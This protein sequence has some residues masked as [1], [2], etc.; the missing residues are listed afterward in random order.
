M[1]LKKLSLAISILML[2]FSPF[3]WNGAEVH[4][5][6][7]M[8][9]GTLNPDSSALLHIDN[10]LQ[11]KGL[12]IPR[13]GTADRDN[14]SNPAN[15]LLIYNTECNVFNYYK[16]DHWVSINGITIS[17]GTILGDPHP[18]QVDTA[19]YSIPQVAG[20]SN[21]IWTVP[22]GA[23]ILSGQGTNTIT[24]LFGSADGNVC[25]SA[26]NTCGDADSLCLSI[27]LAT[28]AFPPTA[29]AP[30]DFTCTSV[31]ANW[32][33]VVNTSQYLLYV[34][35]NNTFSSLLSGYPVS[36]PSNQTSQ[37][38]SGLSQ[39]T[40]YYYRVRVVN[41][42]DTS[43]YSNVVSF[44]TIPPAAPT[45]TAASN[46][47]CTGF[48]A[49][50]GPIVGV[51]HYLLEVST[52]S[53]F[54]SLLNGYPDSL[55]SSN[56]YALVGPIQPNTTYYYRVR[57]A[58]SCD[59][60]GY[61]NTVSISTSAP[62]APTA[63]AA[64]DFQCNPFS[65]RA[66]WGA[67]LAAVNY[68][69]DVSTDPQFGTYVGPYHNFTSGGNTS[70]VI[71][72]AVQG[73]ATY[74]YRIRALGCDTSGYSNTILA[75]TYPPVA[76]VATPPSNFT[77][78]SFSANWEAVN[79]AIT[80][81]LDVALDAGFTSYVTGYNDTVIGNVL[82][83]N[84][85]GLTS[86]ITYYYRVRA[87]DGCNISGNSNV[88]TLGTTAPV[89]PTATPADIYN[90]TTAN[91]NWG[92]VSG[93]TQYYIDLSIDINFSTFVNGIH[94]S[95]VGSVTT[96]N[97]GN[98]PTNT[99]YYFRVRAFNGCDTSGYSN[100]VAFG[101]TTPIAPTAT[102]ADN[103][104]CTSANAN[105][106]AV[107]G[108][109][110][111]YLD[112]SDDPGFATF[113]NN[114]HNVE[115]IGNNTTTYNITGL[116]TNTTYYY[117]VRSYN[118]CDTST[119]SNRI[120]FGT[121]PPNAPTATPADGYT[122]TSAYINWG[123]VPGAIGY[124]IDVAS[125]S[126]YLPTT[127]LPAYDSL[128]VQN[129]T[130]YNIDSLTPNTTYYFRVRAYNGC[131]VSSVSN[132]V[133]F[134]TSAPT[135]PTVTPPTT[136]N[137]TSLTASWG[138]VAGATDYI[139]EVSM[140]VN[141]VSYVNG[142][143]DS[144]GNVTSFTV[145]GLTP[146]VYYYY[147]V[148]AYNGCTVSTWSNVIS[149]GTT[150]P[151]APTATAAT[152]FSCT[153]FN[154]N[155]G[156]VQGASNYIL[157]V[158]TTPTFDNTSILPAYNNLSV[159]NVTTYHV[160]SLPIN[161]TYY[162][163]V[164]ADN[165][166]SISTFSNRIS[167]GTTAP[168]APTAT[169]ASDYT[170]TSFN[171][172]WGAVVGAT[173]YIL[174]VATTASFG[175]STLS[176]Y[177]NLNVGP[178][179]T[180]NVDSLTPNVVYFYRVRAYSGCDTSG[181]SNPVVVGTTSPTAPTA[182]PANN[183]S[184][185][186]FSANW[187]SVQGAI[188]Y[189]IDV[190]VNASF[191]SNT[192]VGN[193]LNYNA[194]PVNTLSI[195]G[196]STNV[197]YYYRVRAFNGCD[198]STYS[199]IINAGTTPPIAPTATPGSD[200]TCN[201]FNANW[202]AVSG[203]INYLLDVS[204]DP[205]FSSFVSG[206]QGQ[207]TANVTTFNVIGLTAGVNY[208]YRVRSDNGCDTSGYSNVVAVGTTAPIA[209]TATPA[210][211]FT[212]TSFNANW[213]A[214]TGATAY[215][216]DVSTDINFATGFR[217][218][219]KFVGNATTFNVDSLL[220]NTTYFYR[221]RASNGCLASGASNTITVA[222]TAPVAPTAT[223]PDNFTCTSFNANWGAVTGAI[224]YILDVA[225]NP[226]FSPNLTGYDSINV[227]N[228][229][230]YNISGL[231]SGTTYYYRVRATNGCANSNYS[232]AILVSTT[233][234]VAPTATDA[235]NF[236]C[237]SFNANW[238]AVSGATQYYLDV[239]FDA[240]FSNLVTANGN[241]YNSFNVGA[242]TTYNV[243]GLTANT[244]YHYRVRAGN[245]CD[246]SLASNTITIN[247]SAPVA[248]TATGPDNFTCTS[249]NANWG[250]VTGATYYLLDVAANPNF[251]PNLTGY[252]SLNVGNVTTYNI[253][254]LSSGT[255]YYYRVRATNGC[256]NSNYSNAIV[257]TTTA[258][259]APTA[260]DANNFT[261]T[262]FSANWG[263]VSGA[264][265]YF[266]DVA[267]DVA[268][269]NIVTANSNI[270]NSFNVSTA[271]TYNI[272]GL[273]ANTIYYYRVR[274]G[275]G[276]DTSLASNTITVS[277]TSP[278]APT[279]T[280]PNNFS[281]TS[282]NANWGAVTGATQYILEVATNAN[283][284]P[285]ITAYDTLNVGNVTT[286]IIS[287]LSSGTYFYRVTATNGCSNSNPS[288]TITVSS[289]TPIAPTATEANNFTCTS[290]NANWGAVLGA[291]QYLLE[292][293]TD[294]SFGSTLIGY[295]PRNVGSVTTYNIDSLSIGGTYFYR[296]RATN[297]CANSNYSNTITVTTTAPIA[298][299]ATEPN[300]FTCTSFNANWGAVFGATQYYL[301]VAN[302]PN[303]NPKLAGYDSLNVGNV[304][305]YNVLG[306]QQGVVYYY[307]V[308]ASNGCSVS[309]AS[310]TITL[311][312]TSPV[313]PTATPATNFTCTS[314]NANWGAVGGATQYIIDVS[315]DANFGNYITANSINYNNRN[316]GNVTT[317]NISGLS[318]NATY[319][320]RV[321]S[322]NGCDTSLASNTISVGTT[323]P[324][325]PIATNASNVTC[326]Q[327]NANWASVTAAT[328][329]F[330]DV[331]TDP[332][333][334]TNTFV[335]T[336]QN[337]NVGN[338]TTYLVTGLT[339]NTTYY[340]RVRADNGCTF[341]AY[342]NTINVTTTS[343]IAPISLP[344]DNISCSTF[345]ANW[346]AAI[347]ATSYLLDV[348][349]NGSFT[350]GVVL[351]GFNV[352]NTTTYNVI[353]L[354][355]GQTYYYRVRAMNG[356][357]TSA[358]STIIPI[359]IT[360]PLPPN[361]IDASNITCTSL[362][363]NWGVSSGAIGYYLDV[364][365]D[366]NF[367]SFVSPFNNFYVGNTNTYNIIGLQQNA[368]YYYRVRAVNGCDTSYSSNT[369]TTGTTAP[370]A[371]I[372][373]NGSNFTCSSFN[374]NWSSVLGAV[375][376]YLDVSIDPGFA[377]GSFVVDNSNNITYQ[378]FYVGAA[379]T[380]PVSGL[381]QNTDY[382][383]RVRA[384]N[385]CDTSTYSNAITVSTS[386]PIA[387]TSSGAS[388]LTCT[389]FNANWG[390]V[391]GATTYYLDLSTDPN[392]GSHVTANGITYNGYNVGNV[393]TYNIT[394]LT[395][396]TTYYYRVRSGN[397]CDTSLY[398]NGIMTVTAA[399]FAPIALAASDLNCTSF[400]A[401]WGGS[402]GALN[403]Y[404]DVAVD[405][406]FNSMLPNYNNKNVGNVT[407]YQITGLTQG[408]TYYYR[409]R[410][411]SGCA[412][413]P[414]SNTINI[415]IAAPDAP[416]ALP[417]TNVACTSFNINWSNSVGATTYLIEVSASAQFAT[418]ITG[419]NPKNTNGAVTTYNVTSPNP[420]EIVQGG[421]YFYRVRSING[422]D[423]SGYSNMG[424]VTTAQVDAPIAASASGIACTVFNA[425]WNSVQGATGYVLD[426]SISPNFTPF[427]TANGI[428]YNGYNVGNVNT[429]NVSGLT[430]NTTYYYRVRAVNA[431]AT[432]ANSLTIVAATNAPPAPQAYNATNVTCTSFNA[433]WSAVSGIIGYYID[434]SADP[435]FTDTANFLIHNQSVGNVLTYN[436]T[437]MPG[438]IVYY[439]VRSATACAQS[440]N[441][442][443]IQV[444]PNNLS[445]PVLAAAT[446]VS[447]NSYTASWT[448]VTGA[449]SYSLDVS[450]NSSFTQ[451]FFSSDVGN[452]TTYSVSSLS[453]GRSYWYRVRANN[454]CTSSNNSN[455]RG[456]TTT[457][458][459]QPNVTAATNMTCVSFQANW[460]AVS[461]VLNYNIDVST[462]STFDNMFINN[463]FVAGNVTNYQVTGL[464]A[465]TYYYRIR[466]TN[467]CG[468]G[469]SS[470]IIMV[471]PTAPVKPV[472][473]TTANP[474][475]NSIQIRWSV[476]GGATHYAVQ[477]STNQNFTGTLFFNNGVGN[478][479]TNPESFTVSGISPGVLYYY[480]VRSVNACGT[481]DWSDV[482]T[483][484]YNAPS[485]PTPSVYSQTCTSAVINWQQVLSAN[486]YEV[487]VTE[488]DP[489]FTQDYVINGS[490]TYNNYAV[491]NVGSVTIGGLGTG[492]YYF[493]MRAKD[494][495]G[496]T[497]GWS[498]QSIVISTLPPDIPSVI[499]VN[500]VV[501][502]C[503]S[504]TAQWN[505]ST[506]STSYILE[507]DNN[508]DF[509]STIISQNVGNVTSFNVANLTQG[510]TYHYRVKA[511]NTCGTSAA[512]GVVSLKVDKPDNVVT[513]P[514]TN[515]TANG[516]TANWNDN[517]TNNVTNYTLQVWQQNTFIG[518]NSM[519]NYGS[520]N[521]NLA[522]SYNV[523]NI[524]P[525]SYYGGSADAY[526]RVSA[527]NG[528]GTSTGYS[529]SQVT[530]P[531]CSNCIGVNAP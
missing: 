449:L 120:T 132:T 415:T 211:N 270:Y 267:Y 496:N 255:T 304:T 143:P 282:F 29:L 151:I 448:A 471:S 285:N 197:V 519:P 141:F 112:V 510:T 518:S 87:D 63:T 239:A 475:C 46:V 524:G 464:S 269:T 201:T 298:P 219:N 383:Y 256:A 401:N 349:A 260:T 26:V 88:I 323:S 214:V 325:A 402:I 491:G 432:S 250:A 91:V 27:Q 380:W 376:Y 461:G 504:F 94:D 490:I 368:T 302:N 293:S 292:V 13:M 7:N 310:N 39:N 455:V 439:R 508:N 37:T 98:L 92:A 431:C 83:F 330:L 56:T 387:P 225:A 58:N 145:T 18:C 286:Y 79:G 86:N 16:L 361:A 478:P 223:A 287:S 234:P 49:N 35:T 84:I 407:T 70:I 124:I 470:S 356:C 465:G 395:I 60:S 438:T 520:V 235:N 501:N 100:V 391:V 283:F 187:G 125:N 189:F 19:V 249:F 505:S 485:T 372:A 139:L 382:Y 200:I 291:S 312:T 180:Y 182:I 191:A 484:Q 254:G 55:N 399:P 341:S 351:N 44:S 333:F 436:V 147:R 22:P 523:V 165:G 301:D 129:V 276:C 159:G 427:L 103:F 41:G 166:C 411:A 8:G 74:Y 75:S 406:L 220:A 410:A 229:T 90:C 400:N 454:A 440:I 435:N 59:T 237:T 473:Q 371:P 474:T 42:C 359:A 335:G 163:R 23:S 306:L 259:V 486:N 57:A 109:T 118:G 123:A 350:S 69:I 199:N 389:S 4:G 353:G 511:V 311:S 513:T 210:D 246:T 430:L 101:T 417:A 369:I 483:F 500:P 378:S 111:Y 157:D 152:N 15:G 133:V 21:Y 394:G 224:H 176:A 130:T 126:S 347:G 95:L 53:T 110:H 195:Q 121:T 108:A 144:V 525:S 364:A 428:T 247:S 381:T 362:N 452:I 32:S 240:G 194:G 236:T 167:I 423:T 379:N 137:C 80:Y 148:R 3:L 320:Y 498:T 140:D 36:V 322:S 265:Q 52:I 186:S 230:T 274:A 162:Y 360:A 242:A 258:P 188:T 192:I 136:F 497:S 308:R 348:A 463:Q 28:A 11:N 476:V 433:N 357:D 420:N 62:I 51:T 172:N 398:S 509:S 342:S 294:A 128:Y 477:V 14:I 169:P 488:Y 324:I 233:A 116:T 127:V 243:T 384:A 396:N 77:C 313:S 386:A 76:P 54:T 332:N 374:A 204:V 122:C 480:R 33:P 363:A 131:S 392:Y 263:A 506:G 358:F 404:L 526:Y 67:V 193:Y 442:N 261:C 226:N 331:S 78:T 529:A 317:L 370:V 48:Q 445:A 1:K 502:G 156:A 253:S 279:A 89:A 196:L 68:F 492:L 344:A 2:F 231:S 251:S 459:V 451:I 185:S 284:N 405:P 82:T 424:V 12:L 437:G 412:T 375:A 457:A 72:S 221:V 177:N 305:T 252:D 321:K 531:T 338:V 198:T 107:T 206:Y 272:T 5:Q 467:G 47:T 264:T 419:F 241:T 334:G 366:A 514:A 179:T 117:R 403:Y 190:A 318:S 314:F 414:H 245:G 228:V 385:I 426:V 119:Y 150:P 300:N 99:F 290:F 507:V 6:D 297:G 328:Q 216:L 50:W 288:N 212:C 61:S 447:C 329:Y 346:Q 34:S 174:E 202:G 20:S 102:L 203:A 227:G 434:V 73:N 207:P 441:S 315:T 413:S 345:N 218:N 522:T 530:V 170:C 213:G 354:T 278:V 178:A 390:A 281:C 409:V 517:S 493:R 319:Y 24:V 65:F 244:V 31:V 266:L 238:G 462:Y 43:G 339:V 215:Y 421:T 495:C 30:S 161:V 277:S 456:V 460:S 444:N 114:Y 337:K 482:G 299:T 408:I 280:D 487:T 154:A 472:L 316:V 104:G 443:F 248:P 458:P 521:A 17:G 115:L 146:N 153:S 271:T 158:A 209:P 81:H 105:W 175:N 10:L 113:V 416:A 184:C 527:T 446:N 66:N 528:C 499:G 45:A 64:T 494:N 489:T 25:V 149:F 135:A 343:P 262:S 138:A 397:N 303:F 515:V 450:S 273:A 468:T 71:D 326:T 289:T 168:V 479:N 183:F 40:T 466:A 516:F 327:F 181:Y 512:S 422:C 155:W 96:Y 336:Y 97:I 309:L 295:N 340:F 205:Q 296:V 134:G 418:Y 93:A 393:T 429:F 275:N 373:L 268:F 377:P 352:G 453:Q 85:Q 388:N 222:T 142:Y 171:A 367:T 38:I 503:T 425:N 217:H 365:N 232:N 164:T 208:Y 469:I 173:H 160:D 106:G 307:R 257:I 9:I 355:T 481:S